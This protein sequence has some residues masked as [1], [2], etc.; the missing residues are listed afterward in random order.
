M[1][2]LKTL[3][4]LA[5]FN[6]D[7]KRRVLAE[8]MAQVD[9]VQSRIDALEASVEHE[10]KVASETP[11][12]G[13]VFGQYAARAKAD[14]TTME[15]QLEALQPYVDQ[16]RDQLAEAFEEQK[17]YEITKDR[18]DEADRQDLD[19]KDQAVLDEVGLQAH[20]QK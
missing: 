20:R 7:D 5:K 3:V 19:R 9:A 14:R 17:K 4:R 15:K 1:K 16:A 11:D 12:L 13:P 6:V 8:V 10:R 18:R 2:T